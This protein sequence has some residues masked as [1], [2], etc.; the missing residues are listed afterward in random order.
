MKV[1]LVGAKN[2]NRMLWYCALF[3]SFY[4]VSISYLKLPRH[5]RSRLQSHE[6]W[7]NT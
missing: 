3:R 5:Q 2:S 6:L 1:F 7:I 4:K